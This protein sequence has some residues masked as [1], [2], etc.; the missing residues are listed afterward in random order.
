MKGFN[1]FTADFHLT[2]SWW[3]FPIVVDVLP[4]RQRIDEEAPSQP[5]IQQTLLEHLYESR[6]K[7]I[8]HEDE[9]SN[10]SFNMQIYKNISGF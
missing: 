6:E 7:G 10:R 4:I 9:L 2:K 3:I 5:S 1:Q 8:I